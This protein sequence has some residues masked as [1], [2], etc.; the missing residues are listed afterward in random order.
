MNGIDSN[1]KQLME[2]MAQPL[3]DELK[4]LDIEK[5][6]DR[7]GA[8]FDKGKGIITIDS[9]GRDLHFSYPDFIL[10]EDIENWHHL[11]I[12]NYLI[13]ANGSELSGEWIGLSQ[14]RGG[15]SKGASHDKDISLIFS[16]DL[17]DM[18]IE[19]FDEISR[20]LGGEKVTSKADSSYILNFA[21]RFPVMVSFWAGDDE[22]PNSAKML[23][24]KLCEN[25]LS[26]QN[27]GGACSAIAHEYVRLFKEKRSSLN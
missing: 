20:T 26:E 6:C 25:Y 4:N 10:Q 18:D 5:V 23:V 17:K 11:T 1:K 12:L 15:L 27:C 3:R 22:F 8:L 19:A 24:D 9:L 21:P 14:I 16:R 7:S 13:S 2:Q